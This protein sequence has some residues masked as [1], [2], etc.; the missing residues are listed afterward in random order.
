MNSNKILLGGVV[1]G[2]VFF[3]LGWLLYG[4]LMADYLAS[5]GNQCAMRSMEEF[6]WWSMI[7]SN[8]VGAILL[9]IIMDWSN[10]K[11]VAGGTKVGAIVGLLFGLSIDLNF[12]SM[13]TFFDSLTGVFVDVAI[14]TIMSAVAGAVIGLVMGAGTKK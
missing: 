5:H 3:F 12:Y 7:V 10:N 9:A 8:I 14:Y 1:G 6:I 13:T 4:I 11:S 2:I